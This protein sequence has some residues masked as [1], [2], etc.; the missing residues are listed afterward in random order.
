MTGLPN[1]ANEGATGEVAYVLN[2]NIIPPNA[3]GIDCEGFTLDHDGTFWISDE[4][5]P[6]IIHFDYN[7]NTLERINPF[8]TGAG[9]R[10]IPWCW[11]AA[12]R[13]GEWKD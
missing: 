3:D 11:P 4:Y 7:G 10:K 8:G 5:G 6:H 13:T 9:S 1:P 2:G 12:D